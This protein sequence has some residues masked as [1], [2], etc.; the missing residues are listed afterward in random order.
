MKKTYTFFIKLTFFML[1]P[2][3]FNNGY[4]QTEKQVQEIIKDYDM[5]KAKQL[6]QNVKQRE[7]REK[8]EVEEFARNNNLPIYRENKNG[9]FDQLMRITDG[10]PIYYS[11]DNAEAAISTRVPHLRSGGSLGLNLTGTGIVPR[12][13][14]GGPIHAHQEYAGR[15]AMV[16]NTV[17]NSNSFHAIHVMG[18]IIGS[19]VT[20][21]AKGM[22]SA[23]TSRSFDWDND[24][25][26]AITEAMNGMLL[27]NHSYGT[28]ITNQ[29]T[30]V[31]LPAWYMGSYVQD[32]YNWDEIA[33]TFPNYLPIMS[34]GNDG[35]NNGN[36]T[37]TTVGYDK[38]NGNKNSKNVLTI[39]NARDATVDATGAITAGGAI[40]GS[41]SQGPSDDRRIKPDVSGDGAGTGSGIYSA[42]NGSGTGGSTTQYA[43]MLGT[44]MAAPNV[45][46]TL[47]LVQQH[48]NNVNG[49]FMRAATLKGL[50]CH[51]ATD[52]GRPGPD[53]QYGWGYLD[54][55]KSAETI[56]GNGISSWISE[57]TLTQGQ[58]Y[59]MQVVATGGTTP[60]LGSICWTDVADESKVNN[61]ILNDAVADLT[62]DLDIRI[63]QATNT[64]YPWKLLPV[65][66]DNATRAEDNNVDVVERINI[67]APT[68][69]TTY[70][71]SVTHKGVLADG[72]QKFSLI[73]T[74]ITSNF[75]FKTLADTQLKCSNTGN[76]VYNF[77]VNK[78]GGANVNFTSAN[79]PAGANLVF[80]QSAFSANGTFDVTIS[81]LANV[82]AGS[83]TIDIIGNNGIETEIRKIYLKVFH[84]TFATQTL[85]SP[86]NAQTGATTIQTLTWQNDLNATNW[87]VQV[88]TM[89][90]FSTIAF[91]GNVTTPSFTAIGLASNTTY[92]WRVK[93]NNSCA[94]GTYSTERSFSTAIIDCSNTPFIATD[95]T[96]GTIAATAN[97]IATVPVTVSGGL[98]IGKITATINL[99]HTYVQDMTITLTGPASIGSP[100][101]KLQEEACGGQP[102][103][104]CTYDDLGA[105]AN[106]NPTSPAI[107]GLIKSFELL[108]GLDGLQA[109]GTWILT[110]N[111]PYNGDGGSV[112]SFSLKI[113]NKQIPLSSTSIVS[114][115]NLNIFTQ[116]EKLNIISSEEIQSITVFD[117]LGKNIYKKENVNDKSHVISSFSNKNQVLIV[118]I[119][120]SNGQTV[121]KKVIF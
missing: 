92:Y 44:S 80:S 27:S 19:G 41:S 49:K 93:P 104:D 96:N 38:L 34:A 65:A 97:A 64:F 12:M 98:I 30:G 116:N 10:I 15:I 48:A 89:Q 13:W 102:D 85:L 4:S 7:L 68:A 54:A 83:Y 63:T 73:V 37:P 77:S 46:G 36:A 95:F 61:G 106:C 23:A 5:I 109:D 45:T 111:D 79:V 121:E 1:I 87:D 60:L 8:G 75:T 101:I 81:N 69:G 100:V 40:H 120:L 62:N 115:E 94:A 11:I 26:E 58:T 52:R 66:T 14:D 86:A 107:S 82:A 67:D 28:P 78:L 119:V 103:I 59:T 112:N 39:A 51:T 42:G 43:T 6:L 24:E 33:Y 2:V 56:T 88:S 91:S 29:T 16:D 114:N 25:S 110:V 84:P 31:N 35:G 72:P 50:A 74:G 113:C 99:T 47:T 71:I 118:K 105:A 18:T 55:K 3:V 9:G 32:S 20:A 76:A 117:I 70:T 53:A 17:R 90:N 22:A 108:H 21:A 57:E